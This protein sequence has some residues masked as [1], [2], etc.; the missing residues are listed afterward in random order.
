MNANIRTAQKA[1]LDTINRV[2]D[3]AIMTWD[4]PERVKR[5]SLPSYHY[6]EVDLNHYEIYIALAG[7]RIVGVVAW[8][9]EPHRVAQQQGLLLHGIYVHPDNQRQGLGTQLFHEAEKSVTAQQ[10]D[11][12]LVKA[13]KDAETFYLSRGMHKLAI[14]D[15]EREFANR[16]W[17]PV[18]IRD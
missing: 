9:R 18:E 2:I 10:L 12:I 17:K 15:S 5:L 3:A 1:D 11:G 16:Y 7:A 13:Q 4:L 6:N 14:T 8:D